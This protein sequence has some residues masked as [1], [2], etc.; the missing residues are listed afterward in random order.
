MRES[1]CDTEEKAI[2]EWLDSHEGGYTEEF[3]G[4][5]C[6]DFENNNCSGWTY[7]DG[8]CECGNRRVY[9]ATSKHQDGEWYAYAEA[10]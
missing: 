10:W 8:R 4:K 7:G 5:N 3:S 2:K 9:L 1:K 6:D